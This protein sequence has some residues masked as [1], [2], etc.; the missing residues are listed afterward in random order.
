M[1]YDAILFDLD[2]TLVDTINLYKRA[3]IQ[4]MEH[5]GLKFSEQDFDRLY[6][7]GT[8]FNEW[9]LRVGGTEA[10]VPALRTKRDD[11]YCELLRQHT[12]FYAGATELLHSIQDRPSAIV[13]GSWKRYVDAIDELLDVTA[14][15]DRL[16]TA[17]DLG[18]FHKPHPHGLLLAADSLRVEPSRCLYVGDQMFDV[19]AAKA[20][21]MTSCCIVTGHTPKQAIAE[22]D[23]VVR[24]LPELRQRLLA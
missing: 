18:D 10:Q 3:C 20:A 17:D 9:I 12:V 23:F 7:M 15:V 24:S 1:T 11:A 5:G 16:V 13:T 22:A 14:H 2:G 6:P 19:G 21:G 8:S 4:A